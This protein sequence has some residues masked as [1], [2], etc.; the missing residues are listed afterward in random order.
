[1]WVITGHDVES[2]QAEVRRYGAWNEELQK[3][4]IAAA[5]GERGRND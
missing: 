1:M 4:L 2:F 5:E 3:F